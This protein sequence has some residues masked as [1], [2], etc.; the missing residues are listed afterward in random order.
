ML[1]P[2][3]LGSIAGAY[4]LS[5][6]EQ[7]NIYIKPVVAV[8]TLF[9]GVR[10]IAKAMQRKAVRKPVR[11]IGLLATVGGFLDAVGGGG[12]G[13]IVNSTLI[14]N[15]RNPVYTIGSVNLAEFFVSL[16]S[17]ITFI[18]L[19]GLSHWQVI[20]GLVLGGAL[21][22]PFAAFTLRRVPVKAMFILVGTVVIVLSLRMIYM[23]FF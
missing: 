10:I 17:S 23:S 15:G 1:L 5:S 16:A 18:S 19:I 2:G 20:L 13:P 21:A 8:Y 11:R 4:M 6:F 22:A 14:A 12:W 9:L 3:I 7:Y